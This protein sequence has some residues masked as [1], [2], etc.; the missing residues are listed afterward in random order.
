MNLN[1]KI[2]IICFLIF[3]VSAAYA[4]YFQIR[5]AVDAQ[6]YDQIA[7]NIINGHGYRRQ[8]F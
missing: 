4:F 3:V 1:K 2:F 5:P 8:R 7:I 6:T